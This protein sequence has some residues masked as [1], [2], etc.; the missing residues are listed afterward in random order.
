SSSQTGQDGGGASDGV[1]WLP[2]VSQM[3]AGITRLSA[4]SWPGL[5][6]P[7]TSWPYSKTWMP[8]TGPDITTPGVCRR[9]QLDRVYTL[10]S[11][12]FGT[13]PRGEEPPPFGPDDLRRGLRRLGFAS[14]IFSGFGVTGPSRY[15]KPSFSASVSSL[16]MMTRTWPPA[17][18]LPNS[19][20]SA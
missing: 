6:R 17:L 7:S 18:S 3:K 20:S 12:T 5:S 8:G 11:G 15:S 14:G 2:Q 10:T 19:T 13:E 16:T 9:C 1:N 4:P